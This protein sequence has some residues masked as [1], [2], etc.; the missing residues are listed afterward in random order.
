MCGS[1]VDFDFHVHLLSLPRVFGTEVA[2]I[3]ATVPYLGVDRERVEHSAHRVI[4]D[5]VPNVGIVWAGSPT[6]VLDRERS[7]ALTSLAP[8]LA[9]EG[10]VS[11]DC[12]RVPPRQKWRARHLRAGR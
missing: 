6:H 5:G 8:V 7:V 12:R 9:V 11:T 4:K 3:P 1:P 10:F 2:S